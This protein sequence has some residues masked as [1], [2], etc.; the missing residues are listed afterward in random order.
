MGPEHLADDGIHLNDR[1]SDV[2][3]LLV[4]NVIE[5]SVD[6]SDTDKR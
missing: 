1:G 2:L 6:S 5:P 3:E 4:T